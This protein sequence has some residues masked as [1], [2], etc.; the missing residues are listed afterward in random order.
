MPSVLV[1]GANRGIGFAV[2]SVLHERGWGVVLAA[3]RKTAA[4]EA[5]GLL[6]GSACAVALD[7][8]DPVSVDAAAEAIGP[9]DALVNNAGVLLD[10]GNDPL[11]VP[12]E[13]VRKT[14][15]TNVLGAWRVCQ[16]F[17]PGMVRRG[18]GRVVLISSGTGSLHHGLFTAA[19]GYALSKTAVNA[20]TSLLASHTRGTGV[21][22][23]AVNPGPVR[24]GMM[25]EASRGPEA[26][27]PAIAD[28]VALADDG[29][30]GVLLRDGRPVPW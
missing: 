30:S 28:A 29:P 3:R 27:A 4:A 23:N 5:A 13:R 22:V 21:L 14:L 7:V 1:T 18:W 12:M 11:S 26:A 20:L 2:A 15:E 17:V 25:P 10:R 8:T 24:T 9:V 6:G 19:P 16:R